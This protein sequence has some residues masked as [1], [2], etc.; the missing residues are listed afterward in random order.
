MYYINDIWYIFNY[1]YYLLFQHFQFHK[2][3]EKNSTDQQRLH[4]TM[5]EVIWAHH[6]NLLWPFNE[7]PRWPV[8][9]MW[10]SGDGQNETWWTRT[11]HR[12]SNY[13]HETNIST[14][15]SD[16]DALRCRPAILAAISRCL[17]SSRALLAA[18]GTQFDLQVGGFDDRGPFDGWRLRGERSFATGKIESLR[19]GV[20][21]VQAKNKDNMAAEKS[22]RT[23]QR[24]W[25]N[26]CK[27]WCNSY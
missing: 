15:L 10:T 7:Q 5:H 22:T 17:A 13:R 19:T 11:Q 1:S 12:S 24:Y 2:S 14:S 23:I 16:S 9:L 18:D 20:K 26:N 6:K 4:L 21:I 27:S 8:F 25:F 3:F